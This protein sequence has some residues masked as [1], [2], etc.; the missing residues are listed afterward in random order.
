[1]DLLWEKQKVLKRKSKK[2]KMNLC[3]IFELSFFSLFFYYFCV[4]LEN[5]LDTR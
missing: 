2:I 4:Y 1:M 5:G 3:L